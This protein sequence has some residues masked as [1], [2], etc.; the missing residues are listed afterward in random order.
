MEQRI[1]KQEIAVIGVLLL[2]ALA[3]WAVFGLKSRKGNVASVNYDG[4][5]VMTIPLNEDGF[6][7]V[8]A[9]L[10]VSLEVSGGAIRFVNSQCPDH[11]CEG[12]GYISEVGESAV[13]MPAKV[14][15]TVEE[16]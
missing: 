12:Y 14:A 1:K 3:V 11:I 2:A 5:V 4:S 9:D 10:P 13:C 6:Y 7:Y 16:E 15:V 8:D